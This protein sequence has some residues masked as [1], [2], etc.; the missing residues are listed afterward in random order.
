VITHIDRET[1]N[2]TFITLMSEIGIY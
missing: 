2:L 1:I